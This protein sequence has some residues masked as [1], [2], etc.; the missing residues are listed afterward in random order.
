MSRN[1]M[2]GAVPYLVATAAGVAVGATY[3]LSPLT[4]W[5]G[6]ATA[7]L[8]AWATQRL[9]GWERRW[10]LG[11]L[12]TA[13][14]LRVLAVVLL[15]LTRD[16]EDQYRV[17]FF[18][19]GDG[20]AMKLRSMWIQL[21]WS[22]APLDP[23]VASGAFSRYGRT[24]YHYVLAY[25][26]YVFGPATYGI[27]L[28]NIALFVAGGI[29][30][31]RFVRE[32]YG[33]QTA[34][35]GLMLLMFLPT[36]FLWSVSALKE[37]LQFFLMAVTLVGALVA[38]GGR[39]WLRIAVA[40][41]VSLAALAALDTIRDGML[42]LAVATVV[43][44]L[45]GRFVIRRRYLLI[46]SP[47]VL[48]VG[49][50]YLLQQDEIQ[51]RVMREMVGAITRHLGHVNTDGHA[52]KTLDPRLY[53]P[54]G[55]LDNLDVA[56]TLNSAESLRFVLRSLGSFVIVP[57]PWDVQSLTELAFIPAQLLW[58]CLVVL[59]CIGLLPGIR[60]HSLLTISLGAHAVVAAFIV[61]ASMGNV[62]TLVRHRDMIT[63]FVVWLA[64]LG[65][66]S[67]GTRMA[68][69]QIWRP[70]KLASSDSGSRYSDGEH[71]TP[72]GSFLAEPGLIARAFRSSLVFRV[73]RGATA[74]SQICRVLATFATRRNSSVDSET[75]CQKEAL[76]PRHLAAVVGSGR[77]ATVLARWQAS[78]TAGWPE[79]SIV[80]LARRCLAATSI[81]Q[82]VRLLGWTTIV[83]ASIEAVASGLTADVAAS[84][85]WGV[86][87]FF[88]VLGWTLIVACDATAAAL[89]Q[90]ESRTAK[91]FMKVS[92]FGMSFESVERTPPS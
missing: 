47:L 38:V 7:G 45:V 60:R 88:F 55:S 29:L 44:G 26:Q 78:C 48:M 86:R 70:E 41:V 52:F 72:G 43:L 83:A 32:A 91:S 59:A 22:G 8:V 3:V 79:S 39:S 23:E 37:S 30:L 5:F 75:P 20:A 21:H 65:A 54:I 14:V 73:L 81:P 85:G 10:V 24:G 12:T 53:V 64:S 42:Q 19:D 28:V 4:V 63:P 84:Y 33:P 46:A 49:A 16:P 31:F 89:E 58:Y 77:L 50:W 36:W 66:V 51:A 71:V 40:S 92:A 1:A 87:G 56:G 9:S 82:R 76:V 69:T 62:G 2:D 18:F 35:V 27:H 34:L 11:I 67:I 6:V 80:R 90:W 74:E 17:S 68:A 25:L 15:F 57:L 13:I 61:T